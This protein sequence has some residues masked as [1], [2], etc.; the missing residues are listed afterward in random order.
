MK[1]AEET[2][3]Q[4]RR[5]A[6]ILPKNTKHTTPPKK[7]TRQTRANA[8]NSAKYN[9]GDRVRVQWLDGKNYPATVI[10]KPIASDGNQVC[11][12]FDSLESSDSDHE[13]DFVD[14][15]R[16][17]PM[18]DSDTE[19]IGTNSS[20]WANCSDLDGFIC[21]DDEDEEPQ[22]YNCVDPSDSVAPPTISPGVSTAIRCV[23]NGTVPG[24]SA[25][26]TIDRAIR[27]LSTPLRCS[28]KQSVDWEFLINPNTVPHEDTV[29]NL[30]VGRCAMCQFHP[31][32]LSW[33]FVCGDIGMRLGAD[34]ARK[35]MAVRKLLAWKHHH[36]R[37]PT[38]P[39]NEDVVGVCIHDAVAAWL[40][41]ADEAASAH[42][43]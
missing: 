26:D 22:P 34:C 13:W 14:W 23:L 1:S 16:I 2:S 38:D 19:S 43:V 7:K 5:S 32:P 35:V 3:R 21:S 42:A 36:I 40:Q 12:A 25:M 9:S 24:H 28:C 18:T 33:M 41:A 29:N 11:V 27:D 37:R 15:K 30:G 10:D 4:T 20:G 31:R 17:A 6:K 39:Q 8:T